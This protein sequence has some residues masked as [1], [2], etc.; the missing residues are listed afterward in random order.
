[1][2]ENCDL[3]VYTSD[4]SHFIL[5]ELT[6]TQPKYVSDHLTD[7]TLKIGKKN[8]AISQLKQT[9]KDISDVPPINSFIKQRTTKHCCFF[10]KLPSPPQ[11]I[12]ATNAFNRL[13]SISPNGIHTPNPDIEAWGF[14]FWEFCDNQTYLLSLDILT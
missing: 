7:G 2:R 6:K 1:G 5:N 3:I 11:G 4:S 12:T 8:K 14:E 9:L 13:S 10:N